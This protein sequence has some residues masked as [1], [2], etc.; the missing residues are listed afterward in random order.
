M[1]RLATSHLWAILTYCFEQTVI[2]N[3]LLARYEIPYDSTA[4]LDPVASYLIY[5][6]C[7]V[8]AIS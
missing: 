7:L 3:E 1:V 4:V 8:K 2:I 6:N 5:N